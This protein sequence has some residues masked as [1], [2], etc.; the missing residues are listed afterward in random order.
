MD[1][2]YTKTKQVFGLYSFCIVAVILV[3][4]SILLL[5]CLK[6]FI[7][8]EAEYHLKVI[9]TLAC[10]EVFYSSYPTRNLASISYFLSIYFLTT[11]FVSIIR[12]IYSVMSGKE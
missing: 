3:F 1:Q 12:F 10:L 5:L 2:L 4:L 9:S 6:H 11:F 8:S 7:N